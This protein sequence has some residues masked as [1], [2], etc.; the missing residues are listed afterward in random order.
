MKRFHLLKDRFLFDD[1]E[2]G[3]YFDLYPVKRPAGDEDVFNSAINAAGAA[4]AKITPVGQKWL[5]TLF[6]TEAQMNAMPER[7]KI[8]FSAKSYLMLFKADFTGTTLPRNAWFEVGSGGMICKPIGAQST[9]SYYTDWNVNAL[10]HRFRRVEKKEVDA[11]QYVEPVPPPT[12]PPTPPPAPTDKYV[13]IIARKA[14]GEP[15]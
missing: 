12:P 13:K 9:W 2:S 3:L 8:S 7:Y 4:L 11:Y 5:P 10:G 14:G 1:F 15:G 6:L